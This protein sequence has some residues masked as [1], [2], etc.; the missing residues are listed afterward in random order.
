M[1]LLITG[2]SGFVGTNFIKNASNFNITKIDLLNQKTENIDFS[3]IDAI[4]HLAA[5][6]HQ[7]Q[8][9]P[10]DLYFKTN[11]DLA[12]EVAKRA[13]EQGVKQFVLMSTVKVFGE[14]T[15]GIPAWNENSKCDPQDAYGKSKWEAEKLIQSLEDDNFKVAVVRSPLVYGAGVKANMLNLIKLVDKFPVLPLGG[16]KNKRSMVNVGNLI[17]LL[18]HIITNQVSG[19]FIAGDR[20]SLSTTELVVLIRRSLKKPCYLFKIPKFCILIISI[21]KPKIIDRL[22]GSLE[23]DNSLTNS[24]LNFYPPYSSEYGI[25]EM[26][27]WY[28]SLK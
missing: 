4:L 26:V 16:I 11:R 15:T 27:Q 9:A 5:L 24:K 13:K 3:G 14:S 1:K 20:S 12:Y 28:N 6:V 7:M 23:L 2:S 8:G 22:F 25:E 18:Q 21:I 17:A 10:E 19:I